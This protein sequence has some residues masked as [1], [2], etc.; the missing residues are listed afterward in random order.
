MAQKLT[1]ALT[2][3][4]EQ[5]KAVDIDRNRNLFADL[6]NEEYLG[7]R[8]LEQVQAYT[9]RHIVQPQIDVV[10]ADLKAK[11]A[12]LKVEALKRGL[13]IDAAQAAAVDVISVEAEK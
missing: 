4:D 12:D 2:L 10:V 3:E 8:I 11:P 9:D 13:D 6:S 1:V 7:V 5:L